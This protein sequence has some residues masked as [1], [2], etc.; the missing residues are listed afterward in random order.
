MFKVTV[1]PY[2]I[3]RIV[4]APDSDTASVLAIENVDGVTLSPNIARKFTI[5]ERLGK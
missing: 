4:R 1:L 5:T 3:V 2:N